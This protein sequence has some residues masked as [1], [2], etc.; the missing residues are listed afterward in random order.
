MFHW[1]KS[2]PSHINR[3][4]SWVWCSIQQ[5]YRLFSQN[6]DRGVKTWR[7]ITNNCSKIDSACCHAGVWPHGGSGNKL[8]HWGCSTEVVHQ[9]ALETQSLHGDHFPISV[10]GPAILGAPSASV[11]R[12]TAGLND[13]LLLRV[14][15]DASLDGRVGGTGEMC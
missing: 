12:N 10:R 13:L 3:W 14:F 15:S 7:Q 5:C 1:E 9:P 6:L 11:D 2:T 8:F 4:S